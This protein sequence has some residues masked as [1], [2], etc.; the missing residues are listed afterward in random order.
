ML[1]DRKDKKMRKN[2]RLD[3]TELFRRSVAGYV[4]DL[5]Y[6]ENILF[7]ASSLFIK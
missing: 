7:I 2:I 5:V 1:K 4:V 3:E 6:H